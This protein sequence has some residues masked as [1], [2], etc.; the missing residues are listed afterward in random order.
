MDTCNFTT[1][2]HLRT[3]QA[4]VGVGTGRCKQLEKGEDCA[5]DLLVSFPSS[6]PAASLS[7]GPHQVIFQNVGSFLHCFCNSPQET[8]FHCENGPPK[9]LC[10]KE[11]PQPSLR[12]HSSSPV[13]KTTR[14]VLCTGTFSGRAP[15]NRATSYP[16][17]HASPVIHFIVLC[18]CVSPCVYVCR[19]PRTTFGSWFSL[20]WVLGLKL[21]LSGLCGKLLYPMDQL[22]SP[23]HFCL[24]FCFYKL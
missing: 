24:W 14:K 16:L 10:G 23:F 22:S 19:S 6:H 20:L 7:Q 12:S 8:S 5:A 9:I 1:F 17:L 13:Q 3:W 2:F 21:Q 18:M 11:T 15:C 4:T